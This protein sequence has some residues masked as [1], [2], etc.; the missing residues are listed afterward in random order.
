[1]AQQKEGMAPRHAEHCGVAQVGRGG[2]V[3]R[4]QDR[5]PNRGR[6]ASELWQFCLPH[7]ATG[8]FRRRL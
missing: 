6:A 5:R 3:V 8:V 2:K 7:F 1:M 4:A